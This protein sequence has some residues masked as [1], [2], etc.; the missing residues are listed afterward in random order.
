VWGLKDYSEPVILDAVAN[1]YIMDI[2]V[3]GSLI[4]CLNSQGELYE[5]NPQFGKKLR[6]SELKDK[7][8]LGFSVGESH[9]LIIGDIVDT[10]A[11]EDKPLK[12]LDNLAEP[13]PHRKDKSPLQK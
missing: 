4:Y 12:L 9:S 5:W 6:L 1:H 3:G 7:T 13:T 2:Q 10:V 8:V 11:M